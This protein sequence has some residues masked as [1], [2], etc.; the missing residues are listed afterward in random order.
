[1]NCIFKRESQT[2]EGVD[3]KQKK[4]PCVRTTQFWERFAEWKCHALQWHRE[5]GS[6][7]LFKM[8]DFISQVSVKLLEPMSELHLKA[9]KKKK[10]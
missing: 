1:M 3:Y 9:Q 2:T 8:N 4:T 6:I 10:N 7:L 5:V